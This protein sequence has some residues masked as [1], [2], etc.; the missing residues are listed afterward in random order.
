MDQDSNLFEERGNKHLVPWEWSGYEPSVA[1]SP[2]RKDVEIDGNVFSIQLGGKG[3][4][5]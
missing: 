4:Q 5:K 1:L 2:E 3:E